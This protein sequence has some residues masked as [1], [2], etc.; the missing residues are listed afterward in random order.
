MYRVF[1]SIFLSTFSLT[2]AFAVEEAVDNLLPS[3]FQIGD[4][5]EEY[6]ALIKTHDH[7]LMEVCDNDM[8]AAYSKLSS[9]FREMELHAERRNYNIKGIRIWLH[10][11]WK[12]DG[13]IAHL[14]YHLRPNSRN[15]SIAGLENFLI[16]F[17][18]HYHFPLISKHAY[19]LYT[20]VAF[21][22]YSKRIKGN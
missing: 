13:S 11:F 16:D 12:K 2:A 18:Q 10:I 5:Q 15:V 7:S 21:P 1:F 22:L 8:R 20:N 3:V 14:A 17:I 6:E 19:E 4:F 9:M